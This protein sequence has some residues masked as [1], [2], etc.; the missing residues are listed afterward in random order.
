MKKYIL[1]I[2]MCL[3]L[4]LTFASCVTTAS[5]YTQSYYDD[6]EIVIVDGTCYVY[7]T[8]PTTAFLN[9]LRIVDGSYFYVY[10]GGYLPVVFPRW[11][12]WSPY[13][14]FYYH[15]NRWYWRDRHHY[16][17]YAYRKNTH[18]TD[19]RKPKIRPHTPNNRVLPRQ[20]PKPNV[21]NHRPNRSGSHFSPSSTRTTVNHRNFGGTSR[22][23][24]EGRR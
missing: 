18:W 1:F 9:T 11:E 23:Q 22:P 15:Q 4:T 17:H 6:D 14:Y 10:N 24:R 5:A 20:P 13:R 7:Y 12:V 19:Y 21:N 16:D 3:S 8:N 2:A